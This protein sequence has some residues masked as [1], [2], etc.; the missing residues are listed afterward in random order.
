MTQVRWYWEEEYRLSG[1]IL[2]AGLS[3]ARAK[4]KVPAEGAPDIRKGE[5]TL[6]YTRNS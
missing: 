5:F 3:R 2:K 6:R 1:G 4:D